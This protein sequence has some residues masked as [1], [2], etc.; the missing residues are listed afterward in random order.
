MTPT[1]KQDES[2]AP[3][4]ATRGA[5]AFVAAQ[6]DHRLAKLDALRAQGIDPYP[7]RFDRT[8]MVC[9]AVAAHPDLPAGTETGETVKLAGRALLIRRH[10]GLTFADLRDRTGTIQLLVSRDGPGAGAHAVFC[11][12]DL[13]DWVGVEGEIITTRSGELSVRV[14]GAQLL[15]KSLRALPDKRHGLTDIDT[16]FRERYLDLVVNRAPRQIFEVRFKA[17][18]SIRRNLTERGFT[19]VETPV[20]DTSAG[21]A[22]A[23][24][25]VTHHNAL[26]IDM[27]MRIALELHLKRL[28]VGGLDRVFEMSSVFR[29]EGLDQK[30]NP[31]FTLLEAYQ[32]LADYGDMMDL[33]EDLIRTAALDSIGTTVVEV[34]GRAIDFAKPFHRASM[35]DLVKEFA[36][37]DMHPSMPLEEAREIA[38]RSGIDVEPAW[39]AGRLLSEVYDVHAEDNLFEPTFVTDHP[40]EISPLARAHRDDPTLTERFE[41]V[42]AMRELANAYSEL[43]DPVD[44][45]GRFEDQMRL[46]AAGDDET[47]TI[48]EDYIR[49]LEYGLPPTGGLGVGVDRLVMLLAGVDSI[50]EVILFPTMRPE[51]GMTRA[52]P[53]RW[54]VGSELPTA[55]AMASP[56]A[57]ATA[58]ATPPPG[59]GTPGVVEDAAIVAATHLPQTRAVRWLGWLTFL[60]GFFTLLPSF[61]FVKEIGLRPDPIL[62]RPDRVTSH[63][64]A[65]LVGVGLMVVARQ[66]YRRK[67]RAWQVALLLYAVAAFANLVR[68]PDPVLVMLSVGMI[69]ALV[70]WRGAFVARGDPASMLGVVRFVP[71]YLLAVLI[72]GWVSLWIEADRIPQGLS[73]VGNLET[74]FGGLVGLEGPYTY[75]G[76]F[77]GDFF[78][79]ALLALGIFGILMLAFLI[80]RPIVDRR[81]PT[82]ADR[83]RARALVSQYGSDTLAYFA[84]REDKSYF[85]SSDGR[86]MI[87][88]AYLEGYAL[89]AG[90]PIGHPDAIDAVLDEFLAFCRDRAWH[91]A[92]LAVSESDVPRYRARGLRNLYLGDEAIIPCDTFTLAGGEMKAVRAAVKHVGKTHTFKLMRSTDASPQ[93][94]KQLNA[95]SEQWRGKEPERGF[96]MASSRDVEGLDPELILAVAYDRDERPDGFLR[97]VPCY[98]ADPGYSLDLMRRLP[99]A[100]NGITEYLI[101]NAALGL[102]EQGFRRLSMNFAAWGKLFHEDANLTVWQRLVK[103]VISLLNPYFQIESL[104]SFNLKFQPE[105]YGRSIIVEDVAEMARVGVLY[106]SVEGFLNVPLVGKYLVPAGRS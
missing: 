5:D 49:A 104:Y 68:G 81:G 57:A 37:V 103:R 48:D 47:E 95:I 1:A 76:R 77:F 23:R 38:R 83:E 99:D 42:I 25:F 9:E 22:A 13:G 66:L 19:E 63:I 84:L 69:I 86:A 8:G 28:I 75:T 50:R 106:A 93:L 41:L 55:A 15:A 90:D 100:T 31:E 36:G 45:R 16:R 29:N 27:Y 80:F 64:V 14:T 61:R 40:R 71:I 11:E 10:G 82:P 56:L 24:P 46:K 33:T 91:V 89:A 53:K 2:G 7:V 4:V 58:T 67:H 21:G 26:N 20:L 98:G 94:V 87:A 12:L 60:I 54:M 59:D 52:T 92:F 97:L 102:G 88:Y 70:W 62:S 17:V 105:W 73:L 3:P 96:T 72:F 85:F 34:D 44:Q 78:P 51:A 18:A 101:A 35:I 65:V 6:R 32:A 30:H 74:I 79:A 43:N 39:G